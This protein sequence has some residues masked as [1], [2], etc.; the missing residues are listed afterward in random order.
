MESRKGS[1]KETQGKCARG[2]GLGSW[3]LHGTKKVERRQKENVGHRVALP[4]EE[5][6]L[7]KEYKA[8][9]K[10]NVPDS[11][12]RE[13]TEGQTEEVVELRKRNN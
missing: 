11:W 9:H 7:T 2:R 8:M 5:G 6:E 13:D 12:L 1:R 4:Q 10:D 3:R